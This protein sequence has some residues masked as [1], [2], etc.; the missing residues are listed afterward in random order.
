[1]HIQQDCD[2]SLLLSSVDFVFDPFILN[3]T[4]LLCNTKVEDKPVCILRDNGATAS[5]V[6]VKVVVHPQL[7]VKGI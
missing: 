3:G 2:S 7:P 1:M 5:I 6:S 4:V